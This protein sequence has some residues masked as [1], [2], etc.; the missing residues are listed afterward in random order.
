MNNNLIATTLKQI[1]QDYHY[2]TENNRNWQPLKVT[3]EPFGDSEMT[4]IPFLQELAIL[5]SEGR[6][7]PILA[8]AGYFVALTVMNNEIEQLLPRPE[9]LVST[10]GLK[11]LK[12]LNEMLFLQK[13]GMTN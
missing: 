2:F 8:E 6:V 1:N 13:L 10:L 4:V 7:N 3:L 5:D 12:T 11:F 9:I